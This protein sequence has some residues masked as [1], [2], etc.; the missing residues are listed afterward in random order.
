MKSESSFFW[1]LFMCARAS[2]QVDISSQPHKVSNAS[3]TL[4][5]FLC[6]SPCSPHE[7]SSGLQ[8]LMVFSASSTCLDTVRKS[9]GA[10]L[11]F[12]KHLQ[13]FG[14]TPSGHCAMCGSGC[15]ECTVAG[16]CE[17]CPSLPM[18]NQLFLCSCRLGACELALTA[19]GG[20]VPI[21]LDSFQE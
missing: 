8:N 2:L 1:W 5:N 20:W 19:S 13:D 16:S 15:V 4:R 11:K 18:A 7:N 14:I 6:S 21:A 9:I 12:T 3:R 17:K 10:S